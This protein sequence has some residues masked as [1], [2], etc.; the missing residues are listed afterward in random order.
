MVGKRTLPFCDLPREVILFMILVCQLE[1]RP[2][3][4]HQAVITAKLSG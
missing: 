2:Y 4:L 3:L 1:L